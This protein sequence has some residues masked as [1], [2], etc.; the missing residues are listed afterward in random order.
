MRTIPSTNVISFTSGI[1]HISE[2][3][4]VGKYDFPDNKHWQSPLGVPESHV[5][6]LYDIDNF[7]MKLERFAR[8]K[9]SQWRMLIPRLFKR[10]R[11][12]L[13][14]IFYSTH[15]QP[16]EEQILQRAANLLQLEEDN[17]S[18][19]NLFRYALVKA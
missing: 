8:P 11:T 9:I 18:L 6:N 4:N 1:D 10:I 17:E 14:D 5:K 2:L 15:M 16:E 19:L 7:Y 3:K 12:E 13:L